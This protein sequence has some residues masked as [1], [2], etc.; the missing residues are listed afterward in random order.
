MRRLAA[1][2]GMA[3]A[4]TIAMATPSQAA[5][6]PPDRPLCWLSST[7]TTRPAPA[8]T[9]V[10]TVPSLPPVTVP[11]PPAPPAAP[12][13]APE[14]AQRLLDLANGERAKAG[15]GRLSSR[16]DVVAIALAHSQRM[17]A[18]GNIFHNDS[19]F[20]DAVQR[21]LS[22]KA[23][24]ENVAQNSGVD[25]THTRLM[26]SPGHRANILDPRFSVAGFAVVQAPD[27]RYYTTQAFLQPAGAVAPVA[28]PKPAAPAPRAPAVAATPRPAAVDSTPATTAL[29]EAVP[30]TTLVAPLLEVAPE[31]AGADMDGAVLASGRRAPVA[32][33]TSGIAGRTAPNTWLPAGVLLSLVAL[34]LLQVSRRTGWRSVSLR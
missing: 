1:G 19:Y 9:P 25:D 10:V 11:P 24:G 4:F 23:R 34:G 32:S 21:M 33:A 7:P 31:P 13:T 3:S 22:S 27:G 17:A 14:A 16:D 28:A 8:P 2:M 15:L 12:R 18:A 26:N 30:P 6:C 5:P 29:P 20:T